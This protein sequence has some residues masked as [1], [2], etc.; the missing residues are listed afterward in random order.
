MMESSK[1]LYDN[2]LEGRVNIVEHIIS[3][4]SNSGYSGKEVCKPD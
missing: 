3:E 1:S 2:A 4:E